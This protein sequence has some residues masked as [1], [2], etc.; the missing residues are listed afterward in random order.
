MPAT[1]TPAR[2]DLDLIADLIPLEAR[3]LDIGCGEGELLQ[4]LAQRRKAD[5]RGIELSQQGVNACVAKGL[6]VIQ[7]DAD[8]DLAGY[9]AGGFDYAILSH[10]LQIVR[11]PD[12]VLQ[13]LLRIAGR[14]IVSFPNFAH[15]RLRRDLALTGRMPSSPMLPYQWFDTPN[16]HL[17]TI[18]D[19]VDFVSSR[20]W[21]IETFIAL[22]GK[23]R[24]LRFTRPG[25]AANFFASQ[26][27]FVLAQ[28]P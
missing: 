20:K 2:F 15:W 22:N 19:F 4:R 14:A 11:H 16:I 27:I 1:R 21:G 28:S 12:R 24:P 10:T 26:A 17:C 6:S 13:H 7:G 18:H 5:G 23:G 3:V 9:P 8:T 25:H